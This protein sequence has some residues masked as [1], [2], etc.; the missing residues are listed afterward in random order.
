MA[1]CL[2]I[3]LCGCGV[4]CLRED[5]FNR[6]R[7]FHRRCCCTL[8]RITIAHTI[9]HKTLSGS[10]LKRLHIEPLD[11]C[12]PPCIPNDHEQGP[13]DTFDVTGWPN[14]S[15]SN[16][17]KALL[18]DGLSFEFT[19]CRGLGGENRDQWRVICE[20]TLRRVANSARHPNTSR[21]AIWTELRNGTQKTISHIFVYR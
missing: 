18:F 12:L 20:F 15:G 3:L 11:T 8:C 4:L 19:K 7:C 6:L 5:L 13:R 10:L 16:A 9:R 21:Q 17:K 2:N 14:D 1:I